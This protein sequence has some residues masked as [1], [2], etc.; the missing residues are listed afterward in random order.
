[1]KV[2]K[3]KC[4]GSAKLKLLIDFG[5][6]PVAHN[7]L[8]NEKQEDPFKHPLC[9]HYCEDCGFAQIN[10][11]ISPEYLYTKYNYC[12]SEWKRQPQIPAEIDLLNRNIKNKDIRILEIGCNDGVF[13]KPLSEAGY[14][15]IVGIEA[16]LY[17][18]N[19]AKAYGFDILTDMF[20]ESLARKLKEQY[21]FFDMV[22]LRH[23]L[24][25][26]P[27]LNAFF[28]A[29]D[30]LLHGEQLLFIEIPDFANA[31]KY[32]DCSTIWEEHPNYFTGDVLEFLLGIKG[33]TI[34]EKSFYDYSGGSVCV[35]A[36]KIGAAE[37]RAGVNGNS[38]LYEKFPDVV[39]NYAIKL[40]STLKKAHEKKKIFLYGTGSRAC[41][42]ING[43]GVGEEIDYAV[44]DQKE[45]QGYYMPGCRLP[46][47]SLAEAV[48]RN[49]GGGHMAIFLLAV[50]HENEEI[51]SKNIMSSCHG[52]DVK[53]V[54][55]FA[56][57][58]IFEEVK[59]IDENGEDS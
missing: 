1:M 39:H 15:N 14:K 42:L 41:T 53:I 18:A 30:L 3:C 25:H 7:L 32:G 34:I 37:L 26:I 13:L 6:Q 38:A 48:E 23:V 17:A 57:N 24:E 35:L 21:I 36:K 20:D 29:V 22:V 19:N 44:D 56:P 51:V 54:S 46:I 10:D 28:E 40:K 16:N 58:D 12:F 50:N 4:C 9:L 59:K 45:K 52:E 49:T 2:E 11:P 47:I 27:D 33:Y 43:L 55:L 8:E 5:M 31:L